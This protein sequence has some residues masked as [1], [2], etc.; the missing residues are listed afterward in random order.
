MN[1][2]QIFYLKCILS[3]FIVINSV[4]LIHHSFAAD[5][6]EELKKAIDSKTQE[7]LDVNQKIIQAQKDLDETETKSN[8]LQKELKKADGT[9]SQLNLSIKSSELNIQKLNLE[10]EAL[11]YD[12]NDT[13]S[14]IS[15]KA[16]AI[17]ELLRELQKK[18]AETTL[19]IL[20]KNKTLAENLNEVQNII[21]IN[22]GLSK[23]I[24]DLQNLNTRLSTKLTD[25]SSKKAK[26]VLE[27]KNLKNRQVILQN[28]K[29]DRQS[30]LT[31]TKNQEKTYQQ[32]IAQMEKD[33]ELLSKEIN[34]VEA[35]LRESF[36]PNLLPAKRPG[37]LAWPVK[38]K[39]DGGL[40]FVT[41]KYGKTPYSAALYSTDFHNGFD[42]GVPIGTPVFAAE[43]GRVVTIDNNDKSYWN[44]NQYG[45]YI[46]IKHPDNLTTLYGHLSITVVQK[47]QNLKQGDLIGYSGNSGYS[48][49][50]HL[51]FGVYW[52]P[53]VR[54][55]TAKELEKYYLEVLNLSKKFD[56][57]G[58][59]PIGVTINPEDYL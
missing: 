56:F 8:S 47:N 32:L 51:H 42:L 19:V 10:I 43:A 55:L 50:P 40:A 48:K 16:S 27:N 22:S 13:K 7:L 23:Q 9:I 17:A 24:G 59:V 2:K 18:D 4:F 33:Q 11:K 5:T 30:L 54:L 15:V 21:D 41:Q 36:D 57:P 45:K 39:K 26:V 20:L 49:G 37:V 3:V 31:Q 12:I 28:Q 34:D 52:D 25:S 38:L 6:P 44:K 46:L 14:Q 58:Q 53:S 35:K 29:N 1:A